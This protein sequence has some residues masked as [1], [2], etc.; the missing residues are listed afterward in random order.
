[1]E[2]GAAL[3]ATADPDVI[4]KGAFAIRRNV[5]PGRVSQWISEGKITG[6][7]LV[8]EGRNAQIRESV[9]IA[10]LN[11]KLDVVQRFGNGL[12]TRLDLPAPPPAPMPIPGA[13]PAP[14]PTEPAAPDAPRIDPIEEQIKRERLEQLR[15][16]NRK[17][18]EDEATR[19]GLLVNAE[20]SGQQFGKIAVQ[21]VTIFDGALSSFAA[22][23]SA[24]FQ[25]PQRDVLHLLRGEFRKVRGDAAAAVRRVAADMPATVEQELGGD[26]S[27]ETDAAA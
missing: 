25:L 9:A 14:A 4:T 17:N 20:T 6:A 2:S 18:A 23:I 1:M 26:S 16:A 24:R 22:S 15:R 12:S 10:Q 27:D 11:Q 5:S 8:G 19:A 3:P 13:V 21:L 7:A